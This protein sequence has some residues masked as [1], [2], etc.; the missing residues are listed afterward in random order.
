MSQMENSYYPPRARWYSHLYLLSKI[1]PK[2][3][4]EDPSISFR[5]VLLAIILPTFSFWL[6]KKKLLWQTSFSSYVIAN[7]LFFSLLGSI[8]AN[9]AFGLL[10]AIHTI[11]VIVFIDYFYSKSD[12][13][14]IRSSILRRIVLV[15]GI[16][17]ILT[18][19]IYIPLRN[20][21]IAHLLFPVKKNGQTIIVNKLQSV[22]SIQKNDWIVY[23]IETNSNR[24]IY[25]REGFGLEQIIAFPGDHIQF[26]SDCFYVNKRSFPRL[27]DMPTEG[28]LTVPEKSWFI[29]PHFD[30]FARGNTDISR[31]MMHLAVVPQ[32]SF[33]G[34]PFQHWFWR[35][36]NFS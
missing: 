19:L 23:K 18:Q 16:C 28:E 4:S 11:G 35:K 9:I 31:T 30:I 34:K 1:C 27:A 6:L 33:M 29:W 5:K 21:M 3:Y 22:A 25:I 15:L 26:S 14:Q 8:I 10:I 20:Q 12:D 13:Q 2:F 7:F 17:F 36:Q 24:E 32:S